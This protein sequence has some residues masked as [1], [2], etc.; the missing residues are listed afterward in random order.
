[1]MQKGWLRP[2]SL[3]TSGLAL[4]LQV[5]PHLVDLWRDDYVRGA[6][7][8]PRVKAILDVSRVAA[9]GG[10]YLAVPEGT[11][12]EPV[13]WKVNDLGFSA[14]GYVWARLTGQP[15]K[16]R[17]LMGL[18]LAIL[19]A[20]VVALLA[21]SPPLAR[22]AASGVLMLT[23]IPVAAY[24]SPDPLAA[25]GS[26]VLLGIALAAAVVRP[27][28]YWS[29]AAMGAALFVIHKIR[30]AYGLYAIAALAAV[31][32]WGTW[33][34]R[35]RAP[36][37]RA[38]LVLGAC[39][40]LE[41]PWRLPLAARAADPRVTRQDTLGTHP[42]YIALLEGVGWSDNRWGIKAWDP[43]VATFLAERYGGEPVNV[44]SA[45]SERRARRAYLEL[46]REDPLHLI[47]VYASRLP[48]A[49]NDHVFGGTLGALALLFAVPAAVAFG[50]RQPDAAQ[51]LLLAATA[52]TLCLVF[53]TVVLDPR[54]LYAYPLR[55]AS[56]LT[57]A[58]ASATLWEARGTVRAALRTSPGEAA[59]A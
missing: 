43:W 14:F 12:F 3:A 17:M 40:A 50:W 49:A 44:G 5:Y 22:L 21:A 23:P 25:H 34:A 10:P 6:A 15:L 39:L 57:L 7:W 8:E 36:L 1:M 9:R 4:A 32:L 31:A 54:L 52:L 29:F 56:G 16:R 42:I 26:L 51:G 46:W 53:Q 38:A 27:W 2:T 48:S 58:F 55:I 30:S 45:E 41:V 35:N 20:A 24:R 18:N 19:A 37:L 33:R 47:A 59:A 13:D 11:R 28:P